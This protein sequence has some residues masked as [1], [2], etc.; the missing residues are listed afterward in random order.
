MILDCPCIQ[1]KNIKPNQQNPVEQDEDLIVYVED[2]GCLFL[3]QIIYICNG[4]LDFN[5]NFQNNG[6]FKII[7]I[8]NVRC[9]YK[10]VQITNIDKHAILVTNCSL[11]LL[12]GPQGPPG[13]K[14]PQ[15]YTGERG[16]QGE[17][18]IQ[19]ATGPK[20]ETG[21][22]GETG[23]QGFTGPQG[24]TGPRGFTG[25]TP[26]LPQPRFISYQK[27]FPNIPQT[28][29]ID[30][31]STVNFGTGLGVDIKDSFG[32]VDLFFDSTIQRFNNITNE[33]HLY[34]VGVT[35]IFDGFPNGNGYRRYTIDKYFY[36]DTSTSS[37]SIVNVNGNNGVRSAPL[38][39]IESTVLN[40][41]VTILLEPN[42]YFEVKAQYG[43]T[44]APATL[45][46]YSTNNINFIPAPYPYIAITQIF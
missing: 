11:I 44:T 23:P 42:D 45:L 4:F 30:I 20:G 40:S 26:P 29:D 35:L 21:S 1:I 9:G 18:G 3:D 22:Q 7:N 43:G 33:T 38:G 16:P 14:G 19:G 28:L 39:S 10:M 31:S 2:K 37:E 34:L 5:T 27:T 8:D 13:I 15:G 36:S 25:T 24:E 17:T 46:L 6:Y 12:T 32:T 41:C